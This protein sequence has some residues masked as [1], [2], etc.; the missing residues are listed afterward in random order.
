MS[1]NVCWYNKFG[2]GNLCFRK[3]NLQV[4]KLDIQDMKNLI[5]I[6]KD[7][8]RIVQTEVEEKAT[9]V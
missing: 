3:H 1:Q 8:L 4:L 9:K 2:F 7:Q 5:E 6:K